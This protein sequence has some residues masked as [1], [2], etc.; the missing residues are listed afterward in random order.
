MPRVKVTPSDY[1]HCFSQTVGNIR[2]LKHLVK[3][4]Y[5]YLIRLEDSFFNECA[6][7]I[8]LSDLSAYWERM[9]L[10]QNAIL[11]NRKVK[12]K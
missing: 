6:T 7:E 11:K 2:E 5:E 12:S 4:Y 3:D 8:N 1:R 9:L 10:P